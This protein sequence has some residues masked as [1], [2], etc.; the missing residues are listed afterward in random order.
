MCSIRSDTVKT[1]RTNCYIY[2]L[3]QFI[4]NLFSY[5][6]NYQRFIKNPV[7]KSLHLTKF[8]RKPLKTTPFENQ[9]T[10]LL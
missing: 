3:A 8:I 7:T 10:G 2:F 9:A 6:N 1:C 5:N 4:I